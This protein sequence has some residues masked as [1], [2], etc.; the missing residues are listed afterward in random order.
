MLHSSSFKQP[1][2]SCSC[3]KNLKQD[4][5]SEYKEISAT[6]C[7][8]FGYLLFDFSEQTEHKLM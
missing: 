7:Q 5:T 3:A 8:L 4:E 6:N 1:T 2:S